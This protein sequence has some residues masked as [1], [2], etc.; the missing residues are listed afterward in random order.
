MEQPDAPTPSPPDE[1]G[2][3]HEESAHESGA[4]HS[5][6]SSGPLFTT[7]VI[8]AMLSLSG[9]LGGALFSNWDKI[10]GGGNHHN[11]KTAA[12]VAVAE[13]HQ[14]SSSAS[15]SS[16]AALQGVWLSPVQQHPYQPDRFFKLRLELN[17]AGGELTGRVSD[18][19]EGS[20]SNG[21]SA[22]SSEILSPRAV[23]EGIDFQIANRWCC[24]DGKE[25]PYETFYQVRP[26]SQGLAVTRRNNAP[27]GGKVERFL[28]S[29]SD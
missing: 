17:T 28:L 4:E 5:S 24:E 14:P 10:F 27:S 25:R 29:R 8:V 22:P 11:T 19:V 26:T 18:V 20:N 23:A 3:P 13:S 2:K 16:M 7:P 6:S 21:T 12:P 1:P 9:V 15:S